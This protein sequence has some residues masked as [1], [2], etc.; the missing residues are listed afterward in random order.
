M[1]TGPAVAPAISEALIRV[2]V[3]RYWDAIVSKDTTTLAEFYA[4]ECSVFGTYSTHP[5]PGRLAAVRRER[6]YLGLGTTIQVRLGT[7]D[8]V[9]IGDGAAVASYNFAFHASHVS[10][11][12]EAEENF[13]DGRAT[14]VF[15]YDLEGRLRIF[16]EHISLP[17]R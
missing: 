8:V 16:S 9:L 1:A 15:G 14:Q 6:Q 13:E 10:G 5:E 3:R 4:G 12:R 17:A 2:E 11:N 7:I